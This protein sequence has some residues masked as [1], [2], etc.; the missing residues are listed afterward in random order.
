MNNLYK[1][2]ITN[3]KSSLED[4]TH[5]NNDT[6][7]FQYL[8]YFRFIK[9]AHST[10][11]GETFKHTFPYLIKS[12]YTLSYGYMFTDMVYHV[13]PMYYSE[14]GFGKKTQDELKYYSVWHSIASFA[15]PS[16]VIGGTKKIMTM[17]HIKAHYIKW[18]LPILGIG[19][20]PFV[21][22]PIN[23]FTEKYIMYCYFPQ[24]FK[25]KHPNKFKL[26]QL[27]DNVS[28]SNPPTSSITYDEIVIQR[29]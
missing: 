14:N 18:G 10:K 9:L 21:I 15:L 7:K 4:P 2:I 11:I 27:N 29:G 26:Y 24:Q 19:M 16:L 13:Y 3:V 6:N 1:N 28:S 25:H 22:N 8:S 5:I 20:I 12:T 23:N 17:C